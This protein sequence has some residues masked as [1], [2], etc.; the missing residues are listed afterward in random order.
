MDNEA[1]KPSLY[2][3]QSMDDGRNWVLIL[4]WWGKYREHKELWV[5]QA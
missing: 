1:G 2:A 4:A 3:Q 5:W